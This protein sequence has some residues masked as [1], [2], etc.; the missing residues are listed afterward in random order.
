MQAVRWDLEA[1]NQRLADFLTA[2][3]IAYVDLLPVFRQ[4]AS[5]PN[6]PS[7]HFRHDQHWTVAGHRLAAEAIHDLL[8]SEFGTGLQSTTATGNSS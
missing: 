3:G 6:A 8:M 5:Q 1:P 4:A 7:L 2:E